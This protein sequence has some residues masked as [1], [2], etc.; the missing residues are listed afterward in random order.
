LI[1]FK[2]VGKQTRYNHSYKK[3]RDFLRVP[4]LQ[5]AKPRLNK[6]GS[7]FA[8]LVASIWC[9]NWNIKTRTGHLEFGTF[10]W[11]NIQ[12]VTE[13]Y[14]NIFQKKLPYFAD[15]IYDEKGILVNGNLLDTIR[16]EWLEEKLLK[17]YL[18]ENLGNKNKL[19]KLANDFLKCAKLCEK[20]R[21]LTEIYKKEIF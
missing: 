2:N 15:F 14:Q 7:P 5:G 6:N 16:M 9:F 12:T 19:T 21:F 17:E 18:E 3:F 8:L 1:N 4:E 11:E 13:K 20:I 10:L